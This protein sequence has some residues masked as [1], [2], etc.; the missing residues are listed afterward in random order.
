MKLIVDS[1]STKTLWCLVDD[2]TLVQEVMTDG[3][4]PYV[5][6]L[7]KINSIIQSDLYPQLLHIPECVYY[8]GAG[9]STDENKTILNN[10]LQSV[11]PNLTL[12]VEHDLLAVARAL[13][14]NS[15]GIAVI[16]G[17]GSNSCLYDGVK[18]IKHSPSMGYILGD[19]G[20]GAYIGKKL[21]SDIYYGT[22]PKE[23]IKNYFEYYD[24]DLSSL[25]DLVYKVS[26]ANMFLA[27]KTK[28]LATQIEHEY[29]HQL[30]RDSFDQFILKHIMPYGTSI[31]NKVHCIGSIAY[32]FKD[33]W[34]EALKEKGYE[35]GHYMKQPMQGLIKYHS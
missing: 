22:A 29:V 13:C 2:Q 4:N 26:G 32:H 11:F 33:I 23:L 15:V 12:E 30:I 3:I 17:T 28:W 5:T 8:Y 31:S 20:S 19:E 9:C 27:S 16:L 21:V 34:E 18:I 14:H 10:A 25:L 24:E 35:I 7:E 6:P 1:G